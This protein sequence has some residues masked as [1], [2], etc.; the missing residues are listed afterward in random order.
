MVLCC[1]LQLTGC[2]S[3]TSPDYQV[4]PLAPMNK[5][6]FAFNRH[7]NKDVLFPVVHVYDFV[8]PSF[9]RTGIHNFYSNTMMISSM[10]NDGLQ[11]NWR[12]F[13][14]DAGRFIVN[15]TLGLL[16]LIDVA[17][18][19]GLYNHPQGF[20]YTLSLWGIDSPYLVLPVMGPMTVNDAVG[21][22]PAYFLNPLIYI[23]YHPAWVGYMVG[24]VFFVDV[25]S[26]ALPREQLLTQYAVDPYVS[27]RDAV[28]Q[29]RKHV[30][31]ELRYDGRVPA[32]A[33]DHDGS[34]SVSPALSPALRGQKQDGSQLSPALRGQPAQD[35][36]T[37]SSDKSESL[38]KEQ[39][40]D[41]SQLS[42]A[43][44]SAK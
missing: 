12:Y 13:L 42:P 37:Q 31:L 32:S 23:K 35:Q 24:G 30:L 16:G 2:A 34:A 22:V 27:V 39:Q 26:R 3:R 33:Y 10:V 1:V 43:L 11:A 7:V 19:I 28:L 17:S 18:N 25:A 8:V 6:F 40:T 36:A 29:N 44:R 20:G 5:T 14:N 9:V 21:L 38:H 4:D 41:P 15:S